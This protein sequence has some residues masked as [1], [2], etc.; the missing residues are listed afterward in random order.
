LSAEE[1]TS[2]IPNHVFFAA[3]GDLGY[4]PDPLN[5]NWLFPLDLSTAP[6][7]IGSRDQMSLFG[8]L[9]IPVLDTLELQ[10]SLRFEH[11]DDFGNDINPRIAL[12]YRPIDRLLLR[13]SWGQG[14]R[15]PALSELNLGQ[16]V[17]WDV[18]WDLKRCPDPTFMG[19]SACV[20]RSF[21]TVNSGNPDLKPE[22]SDS[23]SAGFALQ[24]VEQLTVSVDYWRI[25]HENRIIFPG[26]D[27]IL[28]NEDA[29][30]PDIVMRGEPDQWDIDQGLDFP[31]YI[32]Q[33][34]N[35]LLNLAS[36]EVSG[37]D[38]DINFNHETIKA[39]TFGARL[40]WTH[41]S[42]H[43]SAFNI[44]DEPEELAGTWGYPENRVNLDMY[45]LRNNWQ[46]GIY[47]R[48]ID[49][50]ADREAVTR[51]PSQIKWDSQLTFRGIR[52]TALTLG[53][54]NLLDEDPPFSP[55]S[56]S[57]SGQQGF[58][59]QYYSMRGRYFYLQASISF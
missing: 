15:A 26:L 1:Q 58:P 59:G 29:L 51:I 8:E 25:D 43:Q 57:F 50:F 41:L 31:G 32:D 35:I 40:I 54:E 44:A 27:W 2:G 53:I 22:K 45:W 42:S 17:G 16:S 56:S 34:N 6:T 18:A 47:G 11:Y 33:V 14:F 36:Q 19:V 7:V 5:F 10:T 39:G 20:V 12:S 3:V 4:E 23:V 37:Y 48:W 52:N 9:R 13:G 21:F 30:G 24:L 46:L 38:T 28:R 49:G 55:G